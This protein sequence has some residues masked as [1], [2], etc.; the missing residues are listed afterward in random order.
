M[1]DG[2]QRTVRMVTDAE[3]LVLSTVDRIQRKSAE[4][5]VVCS[6]SGPA[7][8][9]YL[10]GEGVCNMLQQ[11]SSENV[12]LKMKDASSPML[13]VSEQKAEKEDFL[14]LIA[15]SWQ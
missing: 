3:K 9:I 6:A 7:V 14:I 4:E 1:G 15:P 12:V 2:I 13:I 10:D 11:F 5:E 8:S